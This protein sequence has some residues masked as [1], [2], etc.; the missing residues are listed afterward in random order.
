MTAAIGHRKGK[1]E[2]KAEGIAEATIENSRANLEM[3]LTA[4]GL[5]L[6][7]SQAKRIARTVDLVVLKQW[8]VRA[9]TATSVDDVFLDG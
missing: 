3:L 7:K 5:I 6:N 8:M 1:A 2:G 9:A 4:R